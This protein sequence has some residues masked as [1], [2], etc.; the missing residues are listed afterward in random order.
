MDLLLHSEYVAAAAAAEMTTMMMTTRTTWFV[1]LQRNIKTG[2]F[3][4]IEIQNRLT[5]AE[6]DDIGMN[7]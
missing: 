1:P 6:N 2:T 5:M 7:H 4:S 3:Q